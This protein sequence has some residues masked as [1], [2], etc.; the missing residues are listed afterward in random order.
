MINGINSFDQP[1]NS[2]EGTYDNIRK[3]INGQGDNYT[4]GCQLDYPYF[5]EHYRMIAINLNKQQVRDADP[6][7]YN[8]DADPNTLQSERSSNDLFHS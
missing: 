8:L 3:I 6:N 5:E 2:D 7:H 1:V 4:T